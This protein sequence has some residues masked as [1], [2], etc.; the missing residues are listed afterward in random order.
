MQHRWYDKN[1]TLSMAISLLQNASHTHQE[2]AAQYLFSLMET[3]GILSSGALDTQTG[4]IQFLFPSLRRSS[5]DAHA[6][7]L[8]EVLK[9]LSNEHQQFLAV[10]LINYIYVLDCGMS[11]FPLTD[12]QE[13]VLTHQPELG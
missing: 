11:D 4:R 1:P 12:P 3:Q 6:R 7:Y 8:V 13:V 2:M 5:F 10:Q 9:R